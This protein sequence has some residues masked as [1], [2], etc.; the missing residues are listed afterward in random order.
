LAASKSANRGDA[1]FS[2][3]QPNSSLIC[4]KFHGDAGPNEVNIDLDQRFAAGA[5]ILQIT[6]IEKGLRMQETL[7]Y[8]PQ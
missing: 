8:Q 1:H 3:T 7:I 5:Y 4:K 2:C 6:G